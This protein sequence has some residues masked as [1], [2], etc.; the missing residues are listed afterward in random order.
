MSRV[1]VGEPCV[2]TSQEWNDMWKRMT[3]A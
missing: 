2:Q 1:F 3:T